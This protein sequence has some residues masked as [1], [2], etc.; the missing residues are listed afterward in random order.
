M[1]WSRWTVVVLAVANAGW[2]L[3]DGSRALVVGDYVTPSSGEYAGQLGPWAAVIEIVGLD[4]RSNVVK[5][6][7][8]SYGIAG[9][10]LAAGFAMNLPGTRQGL[11]ILAVLGLWYVPFGTVANVLI[12]MLLLRSGAA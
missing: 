6:V 7:F 10:L 8:V 5:A 2:M 9:L 11:L 3:F 4:P 12:L 1:H